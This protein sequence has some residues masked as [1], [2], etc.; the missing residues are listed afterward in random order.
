M[1][2]RSGNL[3]WSKEAS[4]DKIVGLCRWQIAI[5]PRI[6]RPF[7][8]IA[9]KK[10]EKENRVNYGCHSSAYKRTTKSSEIK[11]QSPN[12]NDKRTGRW[13]EADSADCTA[14]RNDR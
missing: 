2:D 12:T 14:Y 3:R 1:S 13:R 11:R 4:L 7:E 10:K 6:S 8:V 9:G 5:A